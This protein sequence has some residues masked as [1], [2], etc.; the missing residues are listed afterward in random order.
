MKQYTKHRMFSYDV[1]GSDKFMFSLSDKAK[2]LYFYMN[3]EADNAGFVVNKRVI[4][5]Q[6]DA[7]EDDLQELIDAGYILTF[8]NSDAICIKHWKAN[9]NNLRNSNTNCVTEFDQLE[10]GKRTGE[11]F[12]KGQMPAAEQKPAYEPKANNNDD[13]QPGDEDLQPIEE[14]EATEAAARPDQPGTASTTPE[15]ISND[16]IPSF[17]EVERYFEEQNF[18]D[19]LAKSFYDDLISKNWC[20][21]KGNK[22][23]NWKSFAAWN[24]NNKKKAHEENMK[25]YQQLKTSQQKPAP[26]IDEFRNK[27]QEQPAGQQG[28]YDIFKDS[29]E[30][31]ADHNGFC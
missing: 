18:K 20:D 26:K 3:M 31:F 16:L 6:L 21:S 5:K 10:E 27:S 9:N 22:I 30:I 7:N 28:G 8:E 12:F 24:N 11:Y 17:E 4:M 2:C 15:N 23:E 1:I 19:I 29:E 13:D 14:P 25:S